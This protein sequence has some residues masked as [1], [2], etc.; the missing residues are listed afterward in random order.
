V[1]LGGE[2]QP[3]GLVVEGSV[4]I[5][6]VI[7]ANQGLLGRRLFLLLLGGLDMAQQCGGSFDNLRKM[8]LVCA[9]GIFFLQKSAAYL[10]VVQLVW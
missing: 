10:R 3:H 7:V 9:F 4:L 8:R 5:I 6:G 1:L 2:E